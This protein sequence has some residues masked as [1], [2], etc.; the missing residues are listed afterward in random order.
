VFFVSLLMFLFRGSRALN[1]T[2]CLFFSCS[3]QQR[4]AASD[5]SS[6]RPPPRIFS[7]TCQKHERRQVTLAFVSEPIRGA[8]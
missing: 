3:S 2:H 5:R 4:P 6:W 1:Q 7:R 8:R